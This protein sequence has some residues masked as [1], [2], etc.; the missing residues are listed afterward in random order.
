MATDPFTLV[1]NAIWALLEA[2]TTL[3]AAVA[4]TSRIK[5][6]GSDRMPIKEERGAADRPELRVRPLA[7]K[8]H[9]HRTSN[10]SSVQRTWLVELATG[11]QR[12]DEDLY[13]IEW[14]IYRA[15]ADWPDTLAALTWNG[16]EFAKDL[17]MGEIQNEL[18][19]GEINIRGWRGVMAISVEMWFDT[20]DL[21]P[22]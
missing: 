11:E 8:A 5:F 17:T 18:G 1:H 19:G 4:V 13:P 2:D 16:K 21:P 20:S 15:M 3:T 10:G 22:A 6:T 14:E 12:V 7:G 9:Q